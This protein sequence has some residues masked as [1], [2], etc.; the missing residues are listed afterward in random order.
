MGEK[1]Y[2]RPRL[3]KLLSEMG[4]D[5]EGREAEFCDM[6]ADEMRKL[7]DEGYLAL[8]DYLDEYHQVDYFLGVMDRVG[9]VTAYGRICVWNDELSLEVAG[10]DVDN[11]DPLKQVEFLLETYGADEAYR[12]DSGA[13]R[14]WWD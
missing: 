8:D 6:S 3:L 9:Q 7:I 4:L 11:P 5:V 1:S 2:D 14:V 10:L 13:I 12:I